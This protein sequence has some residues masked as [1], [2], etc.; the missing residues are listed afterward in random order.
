LLLCHL[1]TPAKW[2]IGTRF[3]PYPQ[4]LWIS[5]WMCLGEGA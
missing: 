1:G 5:L 2:L 4:Y 3:F